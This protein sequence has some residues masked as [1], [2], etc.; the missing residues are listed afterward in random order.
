MMRRRRVVR[1][2]RWRTFSFYIYIQS[3]LDD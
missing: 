1:G 3:L 2:L